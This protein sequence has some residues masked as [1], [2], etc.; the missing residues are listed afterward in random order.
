MPAVGDTLT[1]LAPVRGWWSSP[2]LIHL[3]FCIIS[4]TFL[5]SANGFDSSLLNGLQSLPIWLSFMEQPGGKWLGFINTLY[6]IGA[7]VTATA[8][9]W[10]S[11]R[12]GR[13]KVIWL[14]YL[15]LVIG[16]VLQTAAPSRALFMVGRLL[17]GASMGFMNNA[18][19]ALI[20]EVAYPTHQG[21]ATALF[22]TSYYIG[23]IVA[24]WVTFGTRTL[25]SD[26]AWRIPSLCQLLM[27][28]LALPGSW[29]ISESPRWMVSVGQ[30]ETARQTLV[31]IRTDNDPNAPWVEQELHLIQSSIQAEIEAERSSGYAEMVRSPGNRHRLLISVTLGFF[32]QWVGNGLLS[33]YLAIVLKSVGVTSTKDQL[34]ISA[35]LQIWNLLFAVGGALSVERMGRRSLFLLSAFIMLISYGIMTG[36][37]G[38]FVINGDYPT[39]IAFVPFV[40][41]Y[42]A[43]YDIALTPLL[44]SYPCEIWPFRLR[45]RGLTVTWMSCIIAVIFN[46][47]VNPIALEAIGWK[48]YIVYVVLL[49][50][51]G[52]IVFFFYP[53]TRG[54]SLEQMSL[55][56]DKDA[57]IDARSIYPEDDVVKSSA[58]H[59][60]QIM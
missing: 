6:W 44:T 57:P 51:Y 55:V 26:W 40:F 7:A 31:K 50:C 24:A 34:L 42:F 28:L 60:Q 39:G 3:N 17:A 11:N 45:S 13:K 52:I 18:G 29:F 5:S 25:N 53:E 49:I 58:E 43:G 8:A 10:C 59:K 9:G 41:I 2:Y 35:C 14:G 37:Y 36:L 19:P 46:T 38:S 32:D 30:V 33:Y 48:Y 12:Y 22:M 56:F 47:F 4:L 23:S 21:V 54:L 1:S 15:C 20:A 16:T 27:P